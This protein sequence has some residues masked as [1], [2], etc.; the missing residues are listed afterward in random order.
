[1]EELSIGR[2]VLNVSFPLTHA[3]SPRIRS[4]RSKSSSF[5]VSGSGETDQKEAEEP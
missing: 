1:M 2:E 4:W 5:E 3:Q